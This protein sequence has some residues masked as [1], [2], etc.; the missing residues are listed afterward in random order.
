MISN[1]SG[2]VGDFIHVVGSILGAFQGIFE[3]FVDEV[4]L[5]TDTALVGDVSEGHI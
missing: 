3:D 1:G 2:Q 4:G 5:S